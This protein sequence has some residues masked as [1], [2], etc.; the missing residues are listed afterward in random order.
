MKKFKGTAKKK[1][2][3][4]EKNN[5]DVDKK[6]FSLNLVGMNNKR[7]FQKK[8]NQRTTLKVAKRLI[9]RLNLNW[10]IKFSK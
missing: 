7:G 8:L 9:R 10:C 3:N 1:G 6:V 4:E 5:T 2:E